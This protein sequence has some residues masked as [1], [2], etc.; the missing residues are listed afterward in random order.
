MVGNETFNAGLDVVLE[1]LSA[2]LYAGGTLTAAAS[3]LNALCQNRA[4]VGARPPALTAEQSPVVSAP[5][6]SAG[7]VKREVVAPEKPSKNSPFVFPVIPERSVENS[8]E[9]A[10][11]IIRDAVIPCTLCPRLAATRLHAVFGEG[12]SDAELMLVGEAPG[13][14]DDREGHPFS[15][16]AGALLD[17]MLV[18]MGLSRSQVYLTSVL[19]CRPDVPADEPG[20]RPPTMEELSRC[21]PYLASQ[22]SIVKPKVIVAMGAGAMRALFGSTETV[23]KLRSHWHELQGIPVMPTFHPSYLMR[24]QSNS[25]KRKVW[26]DLLQV[27]ERLGYAISEKQKGFF[28]P[29]ASA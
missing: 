18:A 26:E 8:P 13:M 20:S 15:G 24:N 2:R 23:G 14:E 21:A 12:A 6:V 7:K 9:Q 25:E 4:P 17:R 10:L 11:V 27:M 19:K 22:I 5:A 1:A 16:E 3:D 29:R 28:K